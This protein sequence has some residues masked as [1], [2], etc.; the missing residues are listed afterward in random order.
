MA[1]DLI[2][3]TGGTGFLGRHLLPL[4]VAE[5]FHIRL[6]VR[7]T[8]QVDWLPNERIE[9]VYGD[10]TDPCSVDEAMR[11]CRYVV[12]AA[13]HFR[14][15]GA[16]ELFE[17]VNFEGTKHVAQAA[18]DHGVERLVYISSIAVVGDPHLGEL[19]TETA[20]CHPQDAYQ[21]SKL[22]AEGHLQELVAEH[23]LPAIILRPGAFYGPGSTYGFNRLFIEEAMLGWRVK[24]DGGRRVTFPVFVPDVAQAIVLVFTAGQVGEVYNICGRSL[25]HNELNGVVSDLLGIGHWRLSVPRPLMI[26]LA[27]ILEG[28]AKFTRHEPFYPLNLRHYVFNDWQVSNQKAQAELGFRPTLIEE[29]L[30]QTVA[31]YRQMRGR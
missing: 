20:E 28:L 7:Q 14:F 1:D 5:G 23:G 15:W 19:I 21:D 26:A 13:G 2:L 11:G 8:S 29:G 10:V 24:V 30:R 12:H 3:V 27:A 9:L 6:L 17:Q 22:Q 25:T 31:W 18:L 16:P 4:L